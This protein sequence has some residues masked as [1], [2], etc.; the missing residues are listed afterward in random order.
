ML[1]VSLSSS[2]TPS[3]HG[4]FSTVFPS[5]KNIGD[6]VG[7]RA[8]SPIT[9]NGGVRRRDNFQ[10]AAA[11]A[12]DFDDGRFTLADAIAY[13]TTLEIAHVIGTTKSHQVPK[14]RLPAVD[15]FRVVLPAASV[16]TDRGDFEAHMRRLVQDFGADESCVDAGRFFWPC[17]QIVSCRLD[18]TWHRLHWLKGLPAEADALRERRRVIVSQMRACR[19]HGTLPHWIARILAG[20]D[21][22]PSGIRHK[23][24]YKLGARLALAGWDEDKIVAAV[25]KTSLKEIGGAD[26]RRAARNGIEAARVEWK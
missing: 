22:V 26:V 9:W 3:H 20:D 14:G 23:T 24:V 5:E 2:L 15:R 10:S 16:L 7:S 11:A 6:I 8:W 12:L 21:N 4:Q 18:N 19:E 25:M 1:S 17:R 13:F